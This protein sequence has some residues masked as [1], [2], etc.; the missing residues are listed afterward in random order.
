MIVVD[1]VTSILVSEAVKSEK[2]YKIS[3]ERQQNGT[4]IHHILTLK[5]GKI[6]KFCLSESPHYF[7]NT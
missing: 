1:G 7:I 3:Q 6:S 5:N 2:G 4:F